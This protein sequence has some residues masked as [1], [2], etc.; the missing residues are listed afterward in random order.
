[1]TTETARAFYRRQDWNPGYGHKVKT[2]GRLVIVVVDGKELVDVEASIARMAATADPGKMHMSDVNERQRETHRGNA[3]S[4]PTPERTGDSGGS[5]NASYMQAK[6]M[7]EVFEAKTAQLEYEERVGKFLKKT[8]VDSAIFEIA[9]A[10]RDGLTNCA[11]RIGADVA[12]LTN[13]ADCEA[14]IDREHRALL[15]SMMHRIDSQ[16]GARQESAAA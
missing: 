12:G 7:R 9:R 8:E 6:T 15:E 14:V 10:L 3:Y 1:M 2:Q 5:K 11:R 13:A 16:L 4:A